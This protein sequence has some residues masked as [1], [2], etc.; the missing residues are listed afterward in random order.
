MLVLTQLVCGRSKGFREFCTLGYKAMQSVWNQ[1]TYDIKKEAMCFSETSLCLQQ[2]TRRYIPDDRTLHNHRYE[3]LR[4]YI[5]VSQFAFLSRYYYGVKSGIACAEHTA[6]MGEMKN[7][8]VI[9]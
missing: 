1:P 7:S 8:Y 9:L 5:G 4:F 6:F 2:S 3:N